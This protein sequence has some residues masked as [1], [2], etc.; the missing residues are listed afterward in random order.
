M[1]HDNDA[2]ALANMTLW[3]HL[4]KTLNAKGLFTDEDYR[5]LLHGAITDLE[6]HAQGAPAIAV[7]R[8]VAKV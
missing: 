3:L 1:T 2:L 4:V 6:S 5:A 7:I 8:E